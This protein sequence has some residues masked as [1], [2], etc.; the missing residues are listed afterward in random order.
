MGVFK[1]NVVTS[2]V[3]RS[4]TYSRLAY[5]ISAGIGAAGILFCAASAAPP[6]EAY[7]DLPSVR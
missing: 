2:G 1:L 3:Y 7:G 4:M 6:I 5:V